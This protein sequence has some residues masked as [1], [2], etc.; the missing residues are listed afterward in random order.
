[1]KQLALRITRA[2][3]FALVAAVPLVSAG[4]QALPDAKS[5]LAKHEAAIGGRAAMDKHT[6]MRQTGTISIAVMNVTGALEVFRG[7]PALLVQKQSLGPLGDITQGFDGKTAWVTS[8]Q[9][10]LVLDGEAAAELQNQADFFIDYFDPAQAKSAETLELVDFE[11]RKCYKVKVVRL[12]NSETF[13][14]FDVETGLRVGQMLKMQ[15]AGQNL[16]AKVVISDYK[17]FGGVKVPMKIVRKLAMADLVFEVTN[18][19]FDKVDAA[20]FAVPDVI[21]SQIKP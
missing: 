6:S 21:K 18:V 12:N 9:G 13:N 1:M 16:D 10:N 14:F 15:M 19:E 8:A 20:T 5:L 4:A 2:A 17:E 3:A 7:K 11:G